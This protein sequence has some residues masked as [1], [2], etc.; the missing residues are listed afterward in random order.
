MHKRCSVN[1]VIIQIVSTLYWNHHKLQH[2]HNK[3]E[4]KKLWH[5]SICSVVAYEISINDMYVMGIQQIN[6]LRI[7]YKCYKCL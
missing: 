4:E 7:L 5:Y 1:P 3:E 2:R 6:R